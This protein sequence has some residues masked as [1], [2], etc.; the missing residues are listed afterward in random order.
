MSD[1]EHTFEVQVTLSIVLCDECHRWY[2]HE[3]GRWIPCPCCSKR[4][5]DETSEKLERA[6]DEAGRRLEAGKGLIP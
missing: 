2:A 3:K 6:R 5:S 1:R 4:W